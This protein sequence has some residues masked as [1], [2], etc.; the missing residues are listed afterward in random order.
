[1]TVM[2]IRNKVSG[3]RI[4]FIGIMCLAISVF[5]DLFNALGLIQSYGFVSLGMIISTTSILIVAANN[6]TKTY[7]DN[8]KNLKEVTNLKNNLEKKVKEKTLAL[9]LE[10]ESTEIMME[11]IFHQKKARLIA[12]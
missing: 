6:Y 10:M 8:K 12:W 4:F 3:A 7:V 2:G 5:N 1:M 11:Q 9:E